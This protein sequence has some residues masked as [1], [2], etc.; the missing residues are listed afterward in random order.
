MDIGQWLS[1]AGICLL[2][3][4]SPGPSLAV[5]VNAALQSGRNAGVIAAVCHGVATGL[6]GLLTVTGL[7]VLIARSPAVFL[8]IQ[9]AGAFYLIYLGVKSLRSQGSGALT[10]QAKTD[11]RGAAVSGFLV[12]FL[13]PK[14]AIFMLALFAQ[15]LRPDADVVEKGIMAVTVGVVDGAWYCLMALLVSH[16]L[17]FERLRSNSR[18]ID[19]L[20]GVILIALALTVL[21]RALAAA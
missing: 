4:M 8:A 12:A 15:F 3:A 10:A 13:N 9:L 19:R 20:F 14:L 17:F 6:Y 1:L 7:A 18:K 5:V 16:P 11:N 2:G 21:Y